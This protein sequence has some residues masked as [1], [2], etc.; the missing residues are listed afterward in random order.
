MPWKYWVARGITLAILAIVIGL[1]ITLLVVFPPAQLLPIITSMASALG[2]THLA[3]IIVG[4]IV[5]DIAIT[6]ILGIGALIWMMADSKN[7]S[8]AS[9]RVAVTILLMIFVVSLTMLLVVILPPIGLV[10]LITL[11][12]TELSIGHLGAVGIGLA[13]AGIAAGVTLGASLVL[14]GVSEV[15]KL[16]N[17]IR[18]GNSDGKQ[19]D[20]P[21][22]TLIGVELNFMED[23]SA[24]SDEEADEPDA[25]IVSPSGKGVGKELGQQHGYIFQRTSKHNVAADSQNFTKS[26]SY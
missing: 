26:L 20:G 21:R 10:P 9:Q 24:N 11:A 6:T 7:S 23:D 12:A 13:F 19:A 14:C 5:A 8:L 25:E 2:V 15:V 3:P 16:Y 17:K 18:Y 1:V 22:Y 4:L